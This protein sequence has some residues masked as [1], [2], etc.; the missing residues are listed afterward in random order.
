MKLSGHSGN[1]LRSLKRQR[2]SLDNILRSLK[3]QR[4]SDAEERVI[5]MSALK[6]VL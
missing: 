6:G 1:I 4:E 2:E 3:R 5:S